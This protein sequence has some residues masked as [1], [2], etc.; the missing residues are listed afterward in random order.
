MTV[1]G[2]CKIPSYPLIERDLWAF[3]WVGDPKQREASG[4]RRTGAML[5]PE[6]MPK[7]DATAGRGGACCSG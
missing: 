6:L 4:N 5:P 2:V 1:T 7:S 3:I